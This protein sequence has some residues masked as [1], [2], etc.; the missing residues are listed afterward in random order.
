MSITFFIIGA[1]IFAIYLFLMLWNIVDS[2]KKQREENYPNIDNN[3]RLDKNE[4]N[5]SQL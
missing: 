2:N 3:N 4:N 1:I 5:P